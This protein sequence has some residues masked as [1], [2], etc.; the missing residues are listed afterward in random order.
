LTGNN[1]YA[2][3]TTLNSGTLQVGAGGASGTLG[4]GNISTVTGTGID[5]QRTGTLTVP[6]AISGGAS[7]TLNGTGTVILANNNTYNGGTTINTGTLQVGNGGG[8]GSL[9]SP[10]PIV[11]NS[12]LD[13]NTGG[14]FIYGSGGNGI[15]SGS[16]NVIV[17]G[18]GFIKALGNNTYTGWTRID[19]NTTFQPHEGQDGLLASSVAVTNNGTLRLASQLA[20]FI[21]PGPIVGTGRVQIGANNVNVGVITFTGTNT[22]T[23]GTFIGDNQLVLGDNGSAGFGTIAGNVQFVNNFT[24]AQDNPRTLTFN[25]PTGDDFTFGGT[26]TT[27]F[28]TPQVNMGIVQFNGGA[29]VT[30]TGNN[31]YAGGTVINAGIVQVGAGGATGSLGFGPITD[32]SQLII[33]RTGTLALG[34]V[35]GSGSLTKLGTATVTLTGNSSLSGDVDLEAGTFGAAPSATIG[36]LTV[37]GSLT[38]ASGVTV[39]AAVNRALSPSNS[40]YTVAGPIN[41]TNGGTLKLINAGPL[42]QVGD[43]FTIFSQPVTNMTIVSPGFTVQNNL[44]VD[45][46]VTVSAVAPLPTITATTSGAGG[47]T[48]NLT[49]DANWTGGVHLQSQTNGITTGLSTNWV[50]I[51]GTDLSNSFSTPINKRV[52]P[53]NGAV[54]YRLIAP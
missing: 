4:N 8:S 24:V 48:L 31:T 21:Y 42:L 10:S 43:T 40:V 12:L 1:T 3:G 34:T 22:Y 25:R 14:T 36:S 46:S 32:N 47:T 52:S 9:N 23:G 50:T 30:L 27:N 2:N 7:V 37:G 16:G 38:I 19:A 44:G 41:Y 18:G 35:T 45:G 54:F 49:W 51:P 13:F 33:N 28:T 6:G 29:K 17:R 11:N 15:I 53:T 5:F 39:L 26:I 20:T